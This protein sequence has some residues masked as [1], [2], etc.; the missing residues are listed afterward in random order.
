MAVSS[1]RRL[2][3]ERAGAG[4][5]GVASVLAHA[6][7]RSAT[8]RSSGEDVE[9]RS[10]L[11]PAAYRICTRIRF[12]L[13]PGCERNPA[14]TKSECQPREAESLRVSGGG[15]SVT[16]GVAFGPSDEALQTESAATWRVA[17]NVACLANL[18][19]SSSATISRRA[20][21]KKAT[22]FLGGPSTSPN[23]TV[24]EPW[25]RA[26]NGV[27]RTDLLTARAPSQ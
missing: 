19:R 12:E 21:N 16:P 13:S 5:M 17:R 26:A 8:G 18:R 14:L 23:V 15:A 2:W 22:E 24:F 4:R 10:W 9:H 27:R 11:D 6:D 3:S 20:A 7:V 1:R 25:Q